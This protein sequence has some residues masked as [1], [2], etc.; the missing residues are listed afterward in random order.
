MKQ[1]LEVLRAIMHGQPVLGRYVVEGARPGGLYADES[2]GN[3]LFSA[4]AT[5]PPFARVAIKLDLVPTGE[6]RDPLTRAP[7]EGPLARAAAM[8]AR[9]EHPGIVRLVAFGLHERRATLVTEWVEGATLTRTA[10]RLER[11][12]RF[13]VAIQLAEALAC[14]HKEGFLH[15]DVKPENVMVGRVRGKPRA[16]LLD[17]DT[18]LMSLGEERPPSGTL[19]WAAPEQ[20]LDEAAW[21]DRRADVYSLGATLTLLFSGQPPFP[22]DRSEVAF[23]QSLSGTAPRVALSGKPGDTALVELLMAMLA[24][25]RGGR[26]ASMTEVSARLR[27]IRSRARASGATSY[28]GAASG[29]L[30]GPTPAAFERGALDGQ[31]RHARTAVRPLG[32]TDAA[33]RLKQRLGG[34]LHGRALDVVVHACGGVPVVLDATAAELAGE[35][36]GGLATALASAGAGS[37]RL[38]E[39]IE[40]VARWHASQW[41]TAGD[42]AAGRA[43]V[44][45]G[46]LALGVGKV[47]EARAAALRALEQEL[48]PGA[49][50]RAMLVMARVELLARRVEAA[51]TWAER[52][53]APGV[54]REAPQALVGAGPGSA[55]TTQGEGE[56]QGTVIEARL[57][58]GR[59]Q[60]LREQRKEAH[61][62]FASM[63]GRDWAARAS[64]RQAQEAC[65][66][67][68]ALGRMT[69]ALA[70]CAGSAERLEALRD[71]LV[72]ALR[73]D[74]HRRAGFEGPLGDDAAAWRVL[75]LTAWQTGAEPEQ[76]LALAELERLDGL[77]ARAAELLTRG[78]GD[79]L[80]AFAAALDGPLAG[81]AMPE[82]H[83]LPWAD[84]VRA[85]EPEVAQAY[86][87]ALVIR[88]L[89]SPELARAEVARARRAGAW[90]ELAWARLLL[91][92]GNAD[93]ALEALSALTPPEP[94][95]S[96]ARASSITR[97][98]AL[99]A[100]GRRQEAQRVCAE[101][102]PMAS[103]REGAA[104]LA[105]C[106]AAAGSAREAGA[107]AIAA[108]ERG[109]LGA[110]M[111]EP[112]I[113]GLV[114]LG[115]VQDAI[116]VADGARSRIGE[117]SARRALWGALAQRLL[118]P[119]AATREAREVVAALTAGRALVLAV[120]GLERWY[121]ATRSSEA[122][123]HLA[124]ALQQNGRDD[125][126][127]ALCREGLARAEDAALPD[128]GRWRDLL[129]RALLAAGRAEAAAALDIGEPLLCAEIALARRDFPAARAMATAALETTPDD[130]DARVLLAQAALG[131]GDA[132]AALL[133]LETLPDVALRRDASRALCQ[134][135]E[136]LGDAR[137]SAALD[138]ALTHHPG[139]P[140]LWLGRARAALE[141]GDATA[142][143]SAAARALLLDNRNPDSWDGFLVALY[144]DG[145]ASLFDWLAALRAWQRAAGPERHGL[146]L[147]HHIARCI[148]DLDA[149][150]EAG[151]A[152]GPTPTVAEGL[153][154]AFLARGAWADAA[155]A[156]ALLR[157]EPRAWRP[158]AAWMLAANVGS[159][160]ALAWAEAA[161]VAA[162][163]DAE[164]RWL[165]ALLSQARGH[166]PARAAQAPILIPSR[167]FCAALRQLT[168][169]QRAA[170]ERVLEAPHP[171]ATGVALAS[172]QRVAC[173]GDPGEAVL[174]ARGLAE[175]YPDDTAL[176]TWL[177]ACALRAGEDALAA[178]A[179]EWLT[180][181]DSHAPHDAHILDI[182][183]TL[184]E[185]A[186]YAAA[187]D[188]G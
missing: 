116:D 107:V 124:T 112:L 175:R 40:R 28:A 122:L 18:A 149:A 36:S 16:V 140:T 106:L 20:L 66:L 118:H 142:G 14:V 146:A 181:R 77:A 102:V 84:L 133:A 95:P 52:A 71:M 183:R 2:R 103:D 128:T 153:T 157:H 19:G 69:E 130:V 41:A 35:L 46:E 123:D 67:A 132:R 185:H 24:R 43:L 8:L 104:W 110:A 1:T 126:A 115:R 188:G 150:L 105:R 83:A 87:R 82:A 5:T 47:A 72:R 92:E 109:L 131:L 186:R 22:A 152:A 26:P 64:H 141:A 97:C 44:E 89:G 32:P 12:D 78:P 162:P 161:R 91:L 179:R 163:E 4:R 56:D 151:L 74:R 15:R 127:I 177:A 27:E 93:E 13:E 136:Q 156:A 68:L 137:W 154:H 9:L 155:M 119:D 129:A 7:G 164:V 125:E 158:F 50:G 139:D 57:L 172:L 11:D 96:L 143:T 79:L 42:D 31:A 135:L 168:P 144:S 94:E 81:D 167:W 182:L 70:W 54:H 187:R 17:F 159:E 65:A 58:L 29:I 59:C 23:Q 171:G 100:A 120:P 80:G 73:S 121:G 49:R 173:W 113:Q 174:V 165:E 98:L 111:L 134:A 75:A 30:A 60:L 21:L 63:P 160:S 169:P 25:E 34:M 117:D 48:D 76:R 90:G 51:Q 3:P 85:A 61:A 53:L 38:V 99:A 148:G 114:A 145:D 86:A 45:L 170:L 62:L 147:R 184:A 180:S 10:P 101:L 39:R 37:A 176:G 138:A 88:R 178:R 33:L 55:I 6:P 166:A 108:L